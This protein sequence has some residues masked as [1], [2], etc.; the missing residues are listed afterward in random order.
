[1]SLATTLSAL[2]SHDRCNEFLTSKGL[3]TLDDHEKALNLIVKSSGVKS[4]EELSALTV[5]LTQG[6]VT[7]AQLTEVLKAGFPA[8]AGYKVGERH[9]P[10]YLSLCRT[11][12]IKGSI[13]VDFTP[14]K[15]AGKAVKVENNA[16]TDALKA[17]VAE[18]EA[19]IALIREAKTIKDVREVLKTE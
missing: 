3:P 8:S 18:L 16:E 4:Q 13:K 12:K 10:Y 14:P 17:K 7:G 15:G 6:T 19:T 2:V 9:G 5:N 11:G 1:M